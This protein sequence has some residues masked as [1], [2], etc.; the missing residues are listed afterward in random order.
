MAATGRG[1]AAI[2]LAAGSGVRMMAPLN[3]IFLRLG[4]KPI[5]QRTLEEF[6]K[7]P[8]V[9]QLVTVAAPVDR[10]L[11]NGLVLEG[12]ISKPHRIVDGGPTRHASEFNGLLALA[13]DIES[14]N[15]DVVMIHDAVRPFVDRH[16]VEQLIATAREV[17]A[18][19][20]MIPAGDRLV[21]V[22]D[23]GDVGAAEDGL[24]LAQTPQVFDARLVLEAHRRAADAGFMATDTSSVVEWAGHTV[25]VV[26]GRRENIKITTADD[27]LIA[28][29]IA[30]GDA[31]AETAARPD[32]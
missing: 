17:G 16:E 11:C 4:G 6:S 26:A 9:D 24:W 20:L 8:A 30:E 15:V 22:D 21:T 12:Q 23:Q 19:V 2:V 5:L 14:G 32:H 1:V 31:V 18:A 10:E 7:I 13:D 29:L 28:E 25:A 27:M 3:K